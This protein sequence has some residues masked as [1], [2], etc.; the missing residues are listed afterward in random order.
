MQQD[1]TDS[2]QDPAVYSATVTHIG[3]PT[4]FTAH[5]LPEDRRAAVLERTEARIVTIVLGAVSPQAGPRHLE[6]VFG[7]PKWQHPKLP[8]TGE[9]WSAVFNSESGRGKAWCKRTPAARR[10]SCTPVRTPRR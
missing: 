8:E 10:R 5:L 9:R 3:L 4:G 7:W 2:A 1:D 6:H